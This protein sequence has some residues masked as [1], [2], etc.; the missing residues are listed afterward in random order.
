MQKK[1]KKIEARVS[2]RDKEIIRQ[3]ARD[4]KLNITDVI[5]GSIK[6]NYPEY[7]RD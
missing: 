4:K 1:D 3:I 6:K 7:F 2:F 5:L